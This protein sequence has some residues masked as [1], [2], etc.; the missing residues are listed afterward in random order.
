SGVAAAC[1]TRIAYGTT[2]IAPAN[3]AA[4][5]DDVTGRV[6]SDGVCHA[7][8]G[9]AYANLSNGWTPTF[10]GSTSAACRLSFRYSECGGLYTNPV[11]PHDSADP[12]VL[13]DTNRYVLTCTSGNATDAY[14]IYTSTDLA[15]WTLQSHVFPSAQKP[16]WAKSDFW[17]PEIHKVGNHYVAYFSARG[18][19]G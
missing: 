16:A 19:D 11:M 4:S 6:F 18:A 2:W 3:H 8:A 5:Y 9:N 13:Y 10:N 7:T 15:N 1:T 17:A 12:G 14:P